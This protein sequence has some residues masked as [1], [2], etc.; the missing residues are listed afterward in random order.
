MIF[1]FPEDVAFEEGA[2]ASSSL[3]G[4]ESAT[5]LGP[6]TIGILTG[7]VTRRGEAE[8]IFLMESL[9]SRREIV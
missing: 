9:V 2:V 1:K 6:S 4:G 3:M 8:G 7:Q 5:T